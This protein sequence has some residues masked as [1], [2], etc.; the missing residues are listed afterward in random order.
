MHIQARYRAEY[1]VI[2]QKTQH[3]AG[4]ELSLARQ[5]ADT[6]TG[7]L[8]RAL[9]VSGAAS[10]GLTQIDQAES[11]WR[12]GLAVALRNATPEDVEVAQARGNVANA[13]MVKSHYAEAV[14]LQEQALAT[15]EKALGADH[16]MTMGLRR[17]LALSK[18]HLGYYAQARAMME[19]VIAAQKKKLGDQHP[20]VAG[21]EI[22]LGY[23]L[24]D[25]GDADAAD[26][27]LGEAV[28]I[29]DNKYGREYQGT[30]MALR[31]LAAAHTQQGK[32]DLAEKELNEIRVQEDKLDLRAAEGDETDINLGDVMRLRGDAKAAI[33]LN[34][35]ALAIS[36][37]RNSDNSR[38]AADA[39]Q[40][41]AMAL[42]D[43]GDD[44]GAE[45]EFRASLVSRASYLPDAD[46]PSGATTRYDL[47]LLLLKRDATSGEG[48]RLLTEAVASREKFLGPDDTKTRQAREALARFRAAAKT[49][50]KSN[51]AMLQRHH[52]WKPSFEN[53]VA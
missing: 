16:P 13:L 41:L 47:A 45:R 15:E 33:D 12:E 44:A 40:H 29:F 14:P 2:F 34:R 36:V 6:D 37:K 53:L 32:L 48:I 39:H 28:A 31:T 46:D 52:C 24:V 51:T 26:R 7:P 25:S 21:S 5:I 38:Y 4:E 35:E 22:N 27:V 42:R 11:T 30:R 19:Q 50:R 10:W 9:M 8:F 49:T 23:L 17:D 43:S 18:Y 3:F 1:S 20:A